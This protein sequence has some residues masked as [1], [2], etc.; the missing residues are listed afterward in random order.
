LE[1][2]EFRAKEKGEIQKASK[3]DTKI[4]DIKRNMDEGKEA[5]TGIALGLCQRK[6]NLLWYQG[7]IW[8]SNE[9]GIR[10]TLITKHHNLPQAGHGRMAKTTELLSQ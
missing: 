8:I 10:T 9:E 7:R 2:T 5:M 4:Q 1:T 6:G 3:N